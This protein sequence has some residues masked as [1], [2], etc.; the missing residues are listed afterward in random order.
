MNI[1]LDRPPQLAPGPDLM[2]PPEVAAY[3]RVDVTVV[4]RELAAGRWPGAFRLPTGMHWR[5]P[6]ASVEAHIART[7]SGPAVP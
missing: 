2:T 3:F 5:I 7:W 6:R 1:D 4:Y